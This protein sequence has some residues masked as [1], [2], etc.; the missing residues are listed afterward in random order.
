M[1]PKTLW[2]FGFAGY[3]KKLGFLDYESSYSGILF[4]GTK[5]V[6]FQCAKYYNL[7]TNLGF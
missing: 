4:I 6:K 7:N 2:I 1:I 3:A 5:K